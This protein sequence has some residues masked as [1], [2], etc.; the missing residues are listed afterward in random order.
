MKYILFQL[1]H[2]SGYACKKESGPISQSKRHGNRADTVT[3]VYQ[4]MSDINS[5]KDAFRS[6]CY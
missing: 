1:R 5:K 3:S 2:S 4:D 6:S